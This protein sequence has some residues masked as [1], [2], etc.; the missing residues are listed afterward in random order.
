MWLLL[1][2]IHHKL[3][4]IEICS[5]SLQWFFMMMAMSYIECAC[6]KNLKLNLSISMK[7]MYSYWTPFNHSMFLRPPIH[8]NPSPALPVPL[9]FC[10]AFYSE[11][12]NTNLTGSLFCQLTQDYKY[13][14]AG[15]Q[16]TRVTR[17]VSDPGTSMCATVGFTNTEYNMYA[18][19]IRLA[20]GPRCVQVVF[21]L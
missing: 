15:S 3:M 20:L 1:K 6:A 2:V 14:K 18:L 19:E 17:N 10:N 7:W 8:P 13:E 9:C 11:S 21:N 16:N 5:F 4:F 12:W